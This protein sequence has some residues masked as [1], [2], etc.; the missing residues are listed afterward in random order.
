V[1]RPRKRI[2]IVVRRLVPAL[3]IFAAGVVVC[4][5]NRNQWVSFA[6]QGEVRPRKK[7]G[8]VRAIRFASNAIDAHSLDDE[9]AHHLQAINPRADRRLR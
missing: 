7:E 3:A 2:P 9:A 4:V 5:G 6:A 8:L 1:H